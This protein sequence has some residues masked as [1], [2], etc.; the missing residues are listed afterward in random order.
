EAIGDLIRALDYPGSLAPAELERLA[1]AV[2]VHGD[3]IP[4]GLRQRYITRLRAAESAQTLRRRLIAAGSAAAVILVGTLFYL[5]LHAQAR[6]REAE[7][8]AT[9]ISDQL[10]LNDLDHA[11]SLL[12]EYEKNAPD[13]LKYPALI[14]VRQRV[15]IGQS[16]ESDRALQFDK[17]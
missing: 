3:G 7:Q 13:L 9:S 14:E 6:S 1:H 5:A 8:A 11:V 4:E 10:E 12:K 15:E 17:A 16:K 2:Q